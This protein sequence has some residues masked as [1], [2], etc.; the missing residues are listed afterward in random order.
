VDVF[1]D[2]GLNADYSGLGN[3][4]AFLAN[5]DLHWGERDALRVIQADS[6]HLSAA[7]FLRESGGVR[8]R[9]FFVDG[10]HPPT[11]TANDPLLAQRVP[12]SWRF[13]GC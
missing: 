13:G 8:F 1:N 9:L 5:M 6:L 3:L 7:D 11:H 2:Q 4:A 12:M 10:G